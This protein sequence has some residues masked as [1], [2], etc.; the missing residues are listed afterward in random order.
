MSVKTEEGIPIL[1]NKDEIERVSGIV[2]TNALKTLTNSLVKMEAAEVKPGSM[3][4][5]CV[6]PILYEAARRFDYISEGDTD[7]P[8]D[9]FEYVVG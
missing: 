5:T 3:M 4:E 1:D 8:H 2:A 6:W 9:G 7:V